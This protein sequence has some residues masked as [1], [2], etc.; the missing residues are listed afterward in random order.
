MEFCDRGKPR[1]LFV[2]ACPAH[3]SPEFPFTLDLR[4]S[5]RM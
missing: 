2:C 1:R 4:T 3:V 5:V